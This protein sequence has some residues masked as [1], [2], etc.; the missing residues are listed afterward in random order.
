[1]SARK[2]VTRIVIALAL[3]LVSAEGVRAEDK[4]TRK[5]VGDILKRIESNTQKVNLQKQKSALPTFQKSQELAKPAQ[6]VD[7]YQVKPPSRLNPFYEEGTDEAQLEKVTDQGIKQLFKLTN[8]FRNSKRRGELWLRL[9]ELY[10]EK[11]RLIEYRVQQKYDDQIKDFQTGKTKIKPKL[12]LAAAQEYNKK[13][14]QLYEWFLRDF[15]NDPKSDQ[16]LFFLGYNYFELNQPEKGKEYYQRLTKA[17]PKSP[18][19]EE[20]NFALGEYYFER[21]QWADALKH[22]RIVAANKRARLYAFALY[23]T[24]WC[25]YKTGAVKQALVSLERVIRAGRQAKGSNDATAGGASRIRLATEAQRDLVI[26]Y[27]EAGTP[28]GARAYFAEVAGESQVFNLMEKLAYYYA[29]TGNR[30]GSRQIFRELISERPTAPKAYDYQYQI[31]TMYVS[32][33]R[34]EVFRNELYNWIQNYR[35][36]SEWAQANAKDKELV[37]RANQLIETTLR[38]FTLQQHQTAQNSR[39]AAAQKAAKQSYE[40]YFSTFKEGPKI[41]EMHF[42]YAELLFDMGEFDAAAQHY[43][44]IVDNAPNSPYFEKSALNTV[45]AAEKGLPKE[46]DLKKNVGD[47]LEPVPFSKP[48]AVFEAAASRYTK[49]FPKGENVPAMKYKLGALYY[50][51]NQ[52]DKA[53]AMFDNIIKENGKSQYAKFSARLILDMFN[54]KK[55]YAGMENAGQSILANQDLANSELGSEVKGVIQRAQFKKANDLE[56]AKDYPGAAKAYEEFA[57]KYRGS[58]LGTSASYN[59]AVNYERAGDLFK[60]IGMYSVVVADRSDKNADIKEKSNQFLASLYE[61]TGQ[62]KKAAEAFENYARKHEKDKA[63]IAF[64]FNAAVIRDGMNSYNQAE[65]NYKAYFDKS[66]SADKWDALY[67]SAKMN[68]RRK[69]ISKAQEQYQQ[70]SDAGPKNPE[71]YIEAAYRIAKIYKMKNKQKDYEEWCGKII[72]RHKKFSTPER[73]LGA[74]YAAECTYNRVYKTFEEFLAMRISADPAKMQKTLNEKLSVLNRLKE[75]LK[76]VIRYDDGPYVVNSLA[77]IGQANQHMAA[78]IYKVPVPAAIKKDPELLKQYM[79]GIDKF[80]KPF[81]E[82]AV[83]SYES[84]IE[85]G[86]KL[87]GYGEGLKTAE[88]E[89]N[90]LDPAKFPEYGERAMLTKMPDTLEVE[91]E[92]DLGPAFRSKDETML[93]EA[94]SKRLGK[95]QNDLKA[96]NALAVHYFEDGKYGLSRIILSRAQKAH[97]NEPALENNQGVLY[98]SEDKQRPAIAAFRKALE[99]KSS[100]QIAS[101]NLGSIFVEYRDYGRA[102]DLLERGYSAVK[103][104]MKKG[105]GIDIANNYALSLSGSGDTDRAK[106]IYQNILKADSGSVTALLNYS[107]LLIHKLKDKKEGEKQLNRLKFLADDSKT[108]SAI[109][110]MDKVLSEN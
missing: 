101:A 97:A 58:E 91:S 13:A 24:A 66:K 98:L 76:D 41:D 75:Q 40:L 43:G 2:V 74:S 64:Y 84:A 33:D 109:E 28:G 10:V 54:L 61:K 72:F 36:G 29:D 95:D 1:M 90:R 26:F 37:A 32:S 35:P 49:Q 18:Y 27:A 47:S 30:D 71:Q 52:F 20:S 68:E 106:D 86:F 21:E 92:S 107:I 17:F 96:L 16:A 50:Y 77:L 42:F 102:K 105:L 80:A 70:Y 15:P 85:R 38:N 81:Q 104:D 110:A 59:A 103:S 46:S 22:Y 11:S 34:N 83:K 39:V 60:A 94:V 51:H 63:G 62:Y 93:V 53:H 57:T 88:R 78:S 14:I 5:T 100:Y 82:E 55:D 19:I 8:Q 108:R 87:E 9:A 3:V 69:S 23:K 99:M 31:V 48:V 79:A 7:L 56:A 4:R 25:E 6:R 67:L 44:W 65:A 12:N 73:P 89:L 45:L